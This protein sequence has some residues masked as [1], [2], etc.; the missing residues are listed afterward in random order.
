MFFVPRVN[1]IESDEGF[2]V[3][4]LGR[5]GVR[6][7]EGAKTVFVDSEVLAVASSGLV[8][9]PSSI[10]QWDAPFSCDIDDVTREAIVEN[11]RRAFSFR[12]LEIEVMG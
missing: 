11:I 8:I 2:S 7:T 3:E 12:G 10:K 5:T 9:Y 4:V 1:V 6:Y